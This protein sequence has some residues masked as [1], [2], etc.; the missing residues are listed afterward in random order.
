M[1]V[2]LLLK[3]LSLCRWLTLAAILSITL[4]SPQ[5]VD[6]NDERALSTL[7]Q[8]RD[9]DYSDLLSTPSKHELNIDLISDVN[10]TGCKLDESSLIV[11]N[12]KNDT[13]YL[14]HLAEQE[15]SVKR[16][17]ITKLTAKTKTNPH[18][19][20]NKINQVT[21][22][23]TEL[24]NGLSTDRQNT[25]AVQHSK[26]NVISALIAKNEGLTTTEIAKQA[27]NLQ[28]NKRI[29]RSYDSRSVDEQNFLVT[30][31]SYAKMLLSEEMFVY[32][33]NGNY[34]LPLEFFSEQLLLPV[35]VDTETKSAEGWFIDETRLI[36]ISQNLMQYWA[37]NDDCNH[38][39]TTVYHDDWDLYID[40]NIIA[41][42]YGLVIAFDSARQ[43][44][45]IAESEAIPLSQLIARQERFDLFNK[46]KL[47]AK[48]ELI[49]N[50]PKQYANRGDL[51][52]NIDIGV[53]SQRLNHHSTT[54][55]DGAVQG[56]LD[57]LRHNGYFSYSKFDNSTDFTA[58]V[59]KELT[60]SW[61]SH[62]RLGNITSHNLALVSEASSG[63]GAQFSAGNEF[64]S[65]LRHIVVEGETEPGW[66][67]ELYRNNGLID[68]QRVKADGLYRFIKV[69][70]YIGINQYQLRFYGPNGEIRSES[71]SKLLDTSVMEQGSFGMSA[72]AMSREQD[73]LK[74]YY[75]NFNWAVLDNL[76]AGLALIQQQDINEQWQFLPKLS[77]NLLSDS[78]L[79]QLNYVHNEGGHAASIAL[80]GSLDA[81]DWQAE[82][83]SYNSF[84]SWDNA[85]GR[86]KQEANVD[87]SGFFDGVGVN[88]G[89]GGDWQRLSSGG[90]RT[91]IDFN[92]SGQLSVIN[93]SNELRWSAFSNGSKLNERF[94]VSGRIGSWSL[95]SYVDINL[96]PDIEFNQWVANINTTL[97]DAANYQLELRY[98]PS[99]DGD[100]ST[101]NTLSYLFDYGTLR[102]AVDNYA[103]GDWLAQL[104]WNS[105]LLWE[106][107]DNRLFIDRNS[108]INTSSV[109]IIAFQDDNAN[110]LFD[111][112]ELPLPGLKFTGH[113]SPNTMTD[114][115]G[116][117][118][119][120]QL[121]TSRGHKL[122]LN[123]RSLPDPFLVPAASI[124]SVNAHPGFVQPIAF[125]VMFTSEVEGYVYQLA[126]GKRQAAKGVKVTLT[127]TATD[128]QYFARVEYDG[129]FIFEQILPGE[130][131]LKVEDKVEKRILL[132]PGDFYQLE[133]LVL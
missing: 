24:S 104:R 47:N 56:R 119:I 80:Q 58:Y 46:K 78:N 107:T 52:L 95:R 123:E 22:S 30:Q 112:D 129:V 64:N 89:L 101:R 53:R 51:G 27:S 33:L 120:T 100:F 98:Q 10:A 73:D 72:G 8:L 127:S 34:Y 37:N 102:L 86:I 31:I 128:K 21:R 116:E 5:N 19:K 11:S 92:L 14:T 122:A 57:L 125:P 32:H 111:V 121:Q 50:V 84:S 25:S 118:I 59:D 60:D 117:L 68:V 62:Y 110:G 131:E 48:D 15:T 81:I 87:V 2:E 83:S 77:V 4:I 23:K 29:T 106:T 7:I 75:T 26:N 96:S 6:V 82:W 66:D 126:K 114:S 1:N 9:D 63:I 38:L 109:K 69:P 39:K 90:E 54:A 124:I 97:Y 99:L 67:V 16:K 41:Q 28:C 45:S 55:I 36:D 105:S 70:Y 76:T 35:Q 85:E 133:E 113:S 88:W 12:I 130:Y 44:Y 65:D 103:T 3:L 132:K 61:V 115:N 79:L 108:F 93:L 42:M 17:S 94:A 91:Q 13:S 71:F 40:A 20:P 74:Q 43:S 18:S 49:K